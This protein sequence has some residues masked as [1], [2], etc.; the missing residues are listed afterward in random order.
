ME[1]SIF[2]HELRGKT[3]ENIHHASVCVVDEM[4]KVIFS[5]G[6][7]TLPVFY[8]SS[9]KPIQAILPFS[10]GIE[11]KY[12]L[13]PEEMALT[14]ASQRGEYYHQERLESLMGKLEINEGQLI[15]PPA[16]PANEKPKEDCIRRGG[17]KRRLFH[18]CSGKHL[19][20][21]A[22]AREKNWSTVG[23]H[24][25][26]HPLQQEIKKVVA[27]FADMNEHQLIVEVDGCGVPV[28]AMPLKNLAISYLEFVSPTIGNNQLQQVLGSIKT[29]ASMHC[30]YVSSF[31]YL[32]TTLL[33]DKNI[34]AKAGAEGVV[35]LAL[36]AEKLGLAFKIF[37]GTELI[38]PSLIAKVLEELD[39]QNKETIEKLYQLHKNPVYNSKNTQAGTIQVK[40]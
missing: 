11:Q 8:R 22:T 9:M 30:E 36:K 24:L 27:Q 17:Q 34:F 25:L 31:G 18:T 2:I 32:S 21:I 23:Y 39:Y 5:K 37:S 35:C 1:D 26:E 7:M 14:F 13:T 40:L 38:L 6:N 4:K 15:C 29:V 33:E 10:I 28:Y 12:S 20:F 16:Y 3:I 19:A